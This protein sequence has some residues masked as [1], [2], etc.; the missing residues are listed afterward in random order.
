MYDKY[1]ILEHR[2]INDLNSDG[3][4]LRHKKTGAYVTLL[5]NDDE[6]KVFYIGFRTPPVDST[7]VAHIIEH[8]VLCGSKKY[9]VKDPFIELAKGS[10]NTFLNAMTYPDKT[11]YPV[12]SCN[13]QD[14]H[15]LVDVYLDAVFNPNIYREE[16]IFRQEGWHYELENEDSELKLNGVVYNEMKGVYSSPD[17]VVEHEIMVSLYPDSTYG[18]ESG[19]D[20]D[21][22]PDLTYEQF[23][24]FHGRYYHPSNSYIYL[25]GNMDAEEYLKYIDEEYLSK[26]DYLELD[27]NVIPQ[28]PFTSVKRIE[29][30]YSVLSEEDAEGTYFTYNIS[31]GNALDR[32]LYVAL[33]ILEYVLTGAP[34]AIIKQAL[35]DAGIGEEIYSSVEGGIYQPYFA[36]T[37]KGADKEKL[38]LFI[39]IIEDKLKECATGLPEKSLR[40]AINLFEFKYREAD[41]GSYPRG[42]MLGLQA[43]DSWLYDKNE[44]FMHIEANETYEYMRKNIESGYFEGLIK[45]YFINNPH[46]TILTVSPK[47]GLTKEKDDAL[48][49]RLK[50]MKDGLSADEIKALIENTKALKDYQ[51]EPSPEEDLKKIPM[52]K[53][54]DLKKE[55]V[56]PVNEFIDINGTELV[57]HDIFTNGIGYLN[58]L[59]KVDDVPANL[60]P[61]IGI[62]KS[63]LGLVNTDKHSYGD[64][65][66]EVNIH[67]GGISFDTTSFSDYKNPEKF[68]I[69]FKI[70]SK[71][72]YEETAEA[73]ELIKEMI[74]GS[75]FKDKKRM[76]EVLLELKSRIS[77][78]MISS[79]HSVAVMRSLSYASKYAAAIETIN[80]IPKY[81]LLCTLTDDF[82]KNFED[83]S[84]KL[85]D[86][87]NAIFRPENLI[88]SH[89]SSKENLEDL[90][91]NVSVLLKVLYKEPY[92]GDKFVASPVKLNEAFKSA[93][94]VQYVARSGNFLKKGLKYTG[95]L[96]VLRV[97]MGYD[98]LWNNVRV[99][100]GAYGCM[101]SFGKT[102]DC[103]F[104]S[105]RDPKLKETMEVYE[106]AAEYIENI[107]LS[108][109]QVLQFI[110]GTMSDLDVPL[111]PSAKGDYSL[112]SYLTNNPYEDI[113]KDRDEVL[114]ANEEVIRGLGKYIR[115]FVEDGYLCVV[116][117]AEKIEENKEMFMNVRNLL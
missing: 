36:I 22:I 5:L 114:S 4:I 51:S 60:Y 45:K 12:A 42:L 16:K 10:L 38:P 9:P 80:G 7:G 90:K 92:S 6:N 76:N 84:G 47:V 108:D 98:Y 8:S 61:Y 91:N 97:M 41:Y 39:S 117:N 32:K 112:S 52:L 111:T 28:E 104:V 44:P 34:G 11:V 23:L 82:D 89:T 58:L 31:M 72:L 106:N 1:E 70:K 85:S 86:L 24:D 3:L 78:S 27:S 55:A 33:D 83:L 71:F 63:V 103:Y 13:D 56:K 110:I 20:P 64:L 48:K 54:S 88:V 57:Y 50:E 53:L 69:Y 107:E 115:A 95:A 15:N 67:T 79:G 66:D 17:D 96:K 99:L 37:A 19:G 25:Y 73:F 75:D 18:I 2:F 40:A 26:Y 65:F 68:S 77:S 94:Q 116:G 105:Y 29:K 74:L 21:C 49:A 87:M 62:L 100:G 113:Q 102:G 35:T 14:F 46:K 93:G 30:E 43:L 59:F 101:S 81:E 109:R